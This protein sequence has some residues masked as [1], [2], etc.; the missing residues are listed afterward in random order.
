MPRHAIVTCCDA[1]FGDF[2]LGHWLVSLRANV[3][4][5]G[6]DVVVLDYGL[7]GAQR[8]A[9]T[10][11][12]ALVF[13]CK[14]DGVVSNVRYRDICRLLDERDYDQILSVDGGDIIFQADIRPL[15]DQHPGQFRAVPEELQIPFHD[16]LIGRSDLDAER[17]REI[18]AFLRD[19]PMVNAGV[20]FGPA[21]K[22]REFWSFYSETSRAFDCFGMDQMLLNYALYRDGFVAL[23]RGY[24]FVLV[25]ASSRYSVRDGV[26]LDAH[27]T[28][29]PVV[30]NAGNVDTMRAVRE[31][32][33]GAGGNYRRRWVPLRIRL[34]IAQGWLAKLRRK[35]RP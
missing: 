4:L 30:H 7:T 10:G 1:R 22:F 20:L 28:P 35:L 11:Q 21:N 5:S 27:G 3:D 26:F 15:F 24:N 23:D 32:G 14:R 2:L 6:V 34:L 16:L 17:F 25:T 18:L 12:D 13:A 9:L 8:R 19:K 31:F 29:I 33:Y